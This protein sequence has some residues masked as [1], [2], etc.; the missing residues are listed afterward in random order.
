MSETL[1]DNTLFM[2]KSL[3]MLN[4]KLRNSTD[5]KKYPE[6]VFGYN[7]NIMRIKKQ[8]AENEKQKQVYYGA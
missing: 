3:L 1:D 2:L 8:L 7:Q 5:S 6:V 4:I